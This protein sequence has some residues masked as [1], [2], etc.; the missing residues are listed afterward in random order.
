MDRKPQFTHGGIEHATINGHRFHLRRNDPIRENLLWIDGQSPPLVLDRVAS[1]FVSLIIEA[2]WQF[3]QGEGDESEQV[4]QFVVDRMHEKYGRHGIRRVLALAR[5]PTRERIRADLDRIFGTLLCIA[6]GTCPAETGLGMKP[7]DHT[8]WIAPARIDFAVTYQCNLDCGKCY[9]G[10][11]KQGMPELPAEECVKVFEALWKIG[12]PQIVFTGGEPTCRKDLVR[13]VGE[14]EEFVTGLVTNGTMLAGLAKDLRA[15]SLDFV[16]VTLE[17]HNPVTHN[18][19]VGAAFDAW[20]DTVEGIRKALGA[21]LQVVTNTTL[22]TDNS[23]GFLELLRFGKAL[24]LKDMAC[25]D[26]ICSGRGTEA[27]KSKGLDTEDLKEILIEAV[28]VARGLGINL[29]WYTPTCYEKLNPLELGFGAKACSAAA[30]NM[31]IEPDGS[32]LPC[33][34]WPEPVGNV[35]RDPWERIWNHPVCRKLR[36]HGFAHET[37]ACRKCTHVNV[38]G[39]GCP[40]ERELQHEGTKARRHQGEQLT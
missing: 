36:Q 25:N 28:E 19:M 14:A 18:Q 35:L 3:Q 30:H 34:S 17:S 26:L 4:R 9:L 32:V 12:V 40:L 38:C 13:L 27:R 7:I 23:A 21:G 22:T 1:D 6:N 11:D 2:M 39:G 29:Q 8:K 15:A 5:R 20:S 31:T 37:D 16:Q 24:G 10:C 33:Q